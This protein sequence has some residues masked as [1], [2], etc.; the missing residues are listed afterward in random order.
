MS[1]KRALGQFYTTCAAII[2]DG[3]ILPQ[4][5][6]IIEPFA[7]KGDLAIFANREIEMYDI[8]PGEGIIC[9]DTL[10]NPPEYDGKYILTN[11]PFLAR[12]KSR[13]KHIYEKYGADDLY[14]CFILS[15]MQSRPLGGIIILPINFLCSIRAGDILLRKSFV[16]KFN[17]SRVN[18]FDY[19]I[20]SDTSY[21][22][23]A[24]Q[25]SIKEGPETVPIQTH[26]YTGEDVRSFS[27]SFTARNNYTYGGEIYSLPRGSYSVGRLI[28]GMSPNTNILLKCIDDTTLICAT[29][30]ANVYYDETKNR[31]ARSYATLTISPHL[32]MDEQRRLTCLFNSFM[33]KKRAKYHSLF[34]TN[35]RE[36]GRKRISFDLA[37][38]I[39]GYLLARFY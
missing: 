6:P 19:C 30:V 22:I 2:F 7:G 23:C 11:P 16:S 1:D 12:N 17:I 20:F 31:S 33:A 32:T 38:R 10:M 15:F 21:G 18:I 4:D 36:N 5:V 39:I 24:L 29:I 13:Q 9:R 26:I 37:Y 3:M 14:K 28:K 25:F 35:Y 34:L 8:E 27:M